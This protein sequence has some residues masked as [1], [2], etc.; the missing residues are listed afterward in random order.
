M[1]DRVS[2]SGKLI[3]K[4]EVENQKAARTKNNQSPSAIYLNT[5]TDLNRTL[6]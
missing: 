3:R 1:S 6:T 2:N 5:E 4:V